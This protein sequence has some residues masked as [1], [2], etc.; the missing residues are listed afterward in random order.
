MKRPLTGI[1]L[2][3]L[4]V[5]TACGSENTG[6]IDGVDEI[7]FLQRQKRGGTGDIFQYT[8]YMPGARLVKL[9]PP[10]ADG[11]LTVLC[12]DNM[13]PEYANM[14]IMAYDISF[15]AREIVFSAKLSNDQRYS[16]F[17][18]SLDSNTVEQLPTDPNRDY[19]YPVFA[20]GDKIIY[21]SNAIVEEGAPQFRDE[22]ERGTTT[23]LGVISRAGDVDYLGARNLSHRVFPTMMSDGRLLFTQ[24]DHL[25]D[26]NAGH[27]V[28]SNPDLTTVREGF[29][30]EGTGLAN[31]YIKAVEV[32]PGRVVAIATSR[33]MTLQSGAL[34]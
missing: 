28:L 4:L 18:L 34:V 3:A 7:V 8:S 31:S 25:G 27:L 21:M 24:W 15:D 6:P 16:L 30:K 5:V 32:A 1:A 20:P 23:Q 29:G 17:I 9:S 14:D 19:V 26:M 2:S 22:Y 13:G 33:E 11:T 10:T 12:C